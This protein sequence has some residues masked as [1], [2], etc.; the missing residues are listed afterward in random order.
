MKT[1]LKLLPWFCTLWPIKPFENDLLCNFNEARY[2][3][4][5]NYQEPT[6][7]IEN[8]VFN[9][10]LMSGNLCPSTDLDM[11]LKEIS[12][13]LKCGF[14][15]RERSSTNNLTVDMSCS[16]PS[17]SFCS[18]WLSVTMKQTIDSRIHTKYEKHPPSIRHLIN[19]DLPKNP[20]ILSNFPLLR[21]I[22][23]QEARG[24]ERVV[25]VNKQHLVVTSFNL[26]NK[27]G[28]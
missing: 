1:I 28:G 11:K 6:K 8:F 16:H 24:N 3:L 4:V 26:P 18:W 20:T 22:S 25:A 17:C 21:V 13:W 15:P 12:L 9:A 23:S 19:Q 27:K 2:L 10:S 5:Q 14:E 7:S